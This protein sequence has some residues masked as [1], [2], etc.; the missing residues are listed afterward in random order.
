MA[1]LAR[2]PALGDSDV[3]RVLRQREHEHADKL[4]EKLQQR[5]HD[6][7]DSLQERLQQR[8]H[9]HQY[10]LLDRQGAL[11]DFFPTNLA[12]VAIVAVIVLNGGAMLLELGRTT[13]LKMAPFAGGL[14]AGF[15][16]TIFAW[17]VIHRLPSAGARLARHVGRL[18]WFAS[19]ALFAIGSLIAAAS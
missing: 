16:P 3:Q 10:A 8:E 13:P 6:H 18:F 15:I 11:E 9:E 14:I 2:L 4:Q 7:Q 5:E 12:L 19:V 1:Y 17:T